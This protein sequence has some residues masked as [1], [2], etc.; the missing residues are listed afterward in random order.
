MPKEKSSSK[1]EEL[2]RNANP[3]FSKDLGQHI[4]KNPLVVNGI[5]EKV[6]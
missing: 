6:S 4:L 3:L 2:P 1:K 5:I